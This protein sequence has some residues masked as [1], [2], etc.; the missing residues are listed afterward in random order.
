VKEGITSVKN[1]ELLFLKKKLK[2]TLFAVN[3]KPGLI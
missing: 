1:S 2:K 3:F